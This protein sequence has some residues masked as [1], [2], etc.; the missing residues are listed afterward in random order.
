MTTIAYRDGILAADSRTSIQTEAGGS[1]FFKCE[2]LYRVLRGGV[3]NIVGL[4]GESASGLVFLDW[5]QSG[6]K[7]TPEK[8]ITGEA[9]FTALV[10]NR[11]GLFE[12]D[13]W[14]RGEKILGRFYAV[15]SGAK[16]ALGALHM[17]ANARTAV[18]IACKVD[19]YSAGP[20][21]TMSIK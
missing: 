21:V 20:I 17:G 9:D 19:P 11:S 5:Y 10:L 16:A 15:G 18:R 3:L 8:L 4:A 12:F 6:D 7:E 14:C 13:K 1:R 2:K